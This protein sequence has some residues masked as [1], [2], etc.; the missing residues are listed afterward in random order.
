MHNEQTIPPCILDAIE[1]MLSPYGTSLADVSTGYNRRYMTTKQASVYSGLCQKTI[2]E[3]ALENCFDSLR[4]GTSSR[5]RVLID[6]NS[7]DKW[8]NG[9]KHKPILHPEVLNA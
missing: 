3:R 7:F 1:T 8:L 2:R 6:K 5:S 4:L 9:F